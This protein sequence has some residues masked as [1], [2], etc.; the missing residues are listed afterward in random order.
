MLGWNGPF[1]ILNFNFKA[2]DLKYAHGTSELQDVNNL[3]VEWTVFEWIL[4]ISYFMKYL[5]FFYNTNAMAV[6]ILINKI[7]LKAKIAEVATQIK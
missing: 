3:D 2:V 5:N 4:K 7:E 6:Y 1:Q